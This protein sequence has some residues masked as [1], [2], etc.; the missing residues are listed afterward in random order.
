[1]KGVVMIADISGFTKLA[2]LYCK[3]GGVGVEKLT[4]TLNDVFGTMID[5]IDRWG[6]DVI[7][8]AGD[9]IICFVSRSDST[10]LSS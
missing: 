1:M 8:F 4:V 3:E 10:Q 5:G 2:E 6:G 9:A 7:K